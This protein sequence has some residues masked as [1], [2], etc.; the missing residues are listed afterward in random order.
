MTRAAARVITPRRDASAASAARF[1]PRSFAELT[2]SGPMA[3]EGATIP[4]LIRRLRHADATTTPRSFQEIILRLQA[5]WAAQG[6]AI[7]QP[8]D[9][10]VGAGTFHPATTLR[11]LGHE[12]LGGGLCPAL[13]PPDRRALWREP[14]PAAALL[15][16]SGDHQTLAARPAGAVSRRRL[17]PSASTLACTTSALSRM[18]GKARPWAPGAWAGRSGATGWRSASSPISSRSAGMTASPVS[19]AS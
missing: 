11:V 10:E 9:M 12:A 2:L 4:P 15:P 7:L 3:R 6:C 17:R 5:Y 19:R 14:E 13:A 8:Y 1:G 16:V 18:T